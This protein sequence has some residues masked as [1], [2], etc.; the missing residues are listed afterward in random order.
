MPTVFIIHGL[1]G[2]PN[3]NWFPWL[4]SELEKLNYRVFVPQ[5]P[6]PNSQS[7][8]SWL[9]VWKNYEG[10]LESDSILVG[11]SL[12]VPFILNV[13]ERSNKKI[14]STFLVAG[15]VGSLGIPDFDELNASFSDR[16]FNWIKIKENC[17]KFV[18][19]A[20]DNDE[21]VPM[22]KALELKSKLNGELIVINNGGHLNQGAGFRR[23]ELLLE[24][25]TNEI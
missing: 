21:Y 15:F 6:T 8:E 5:F 19:V 10:F 23:F 3:S 11:H 7:L 13:L 12:G 16:E 14:S 17:K 18:I 24:N 9:N 22:E 4:K 25:I 2:T 20:S 1:G